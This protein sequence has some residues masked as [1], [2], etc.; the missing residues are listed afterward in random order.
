MYSAIELNI[1]GRTSKN[2]YMIWVA[3]LTEL[4]YC[5]VAEIIESKIPSFDPYI[6]LKSTLPESDLRHKHDLKLSNLSYECLR[7]EFLASDN[8]DPKTHELIRSIDHYIKIYRLEN[9]PTPSDLQPE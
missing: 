5:I 3:S 8:H 7:N 2:D 9:K 4:K 1:I 6:I